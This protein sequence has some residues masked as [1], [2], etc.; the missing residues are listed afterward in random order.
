MAFDVTHTFLQINGWDITLDSQAIGDFLYG[1]CD[2]NAV[3]YD[4]LETWLRA[5]SRPLG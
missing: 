3:T 1:L 2:N 5:N 4:A